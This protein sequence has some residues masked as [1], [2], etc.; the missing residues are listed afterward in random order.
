MEQGNHRRRTSY[1]LIEVGTALV[2]VLMLLAACGNSANSDASSTGNKNS[3]SSGSASNAQTAANR[4]VASTNASTSTNANATCDQLSKV[5]I[6]EHAV[7][8]KDDQYAFSPANVTIKS[9]EF[10]LFSN[11]TDEVHVLEATP[12]A[13]LD[14]SAIDRNED[15]PVQFTKAGTYTLESQNAKHRATMQV[16]VTNVAG[17][18]CGMSAPSTT[19]TFTEKHVQSSSEQWTL[20]PGTVSLNA[21]QSLILA[22]KTTQALN[23]SCKPSADLTEGNLRVDA[24]EQ[25]VVQFAKAGQ[26]TCSSP[27]APRSTVVVDVH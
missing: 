25:Q 9:G 27:E 5:T 1:R 7:P 2:A 6:S 13:G 15:Q 17:T 22:N 10:I 23:F 14:N 12:A 26:Y 4:D 21:G 18:T 20:T 24:N 3:A 8:G 19:V 11:Q 16:T